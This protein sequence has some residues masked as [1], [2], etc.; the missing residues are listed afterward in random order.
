MGITFR[1]SGYRKRVNY[2]KRTVKQGEAMA[3]WDRYGTHYQIIGPR[4]V[5]LFSSTIEFLDNFIAKGNEYLYITH[6][7]GREEVIRGPTSMFCNPTF[8]RKIEVKEAIFLET[9]NDYI[10]VSRRSTSAT[11]QA[12]FASNVK[13]EVSLDAVSADGIRFDIIRGPMYFFPQVGDIVHS[14]D[15]SLIKQPFQVL[16][17][18]PKLFRFEPSTGES[19]GIKIHVWKQNTLSSSQNHSTTDSLPKPETLTVFPEIVYH[20]DDVNKFINFSDNFYGDLVAYIS[21]DIQE[22]ITSSNQNNNNINNESNDMKSKID[23]PN[24]TLK[25]EISYID[26]SVLFNIGNYQHLQRYCQKI[27]VVIESLRIASIDPDEHYKKQVNEKMKQLHEREKKFHEEEQRHKLADLELNAARERQNDLVEH[28]RKKLEA[29][30]E[31]ETKIREAR[32]Q[33]TLSF[34]DSLKQKGVDLNI[35]FQQV[36]IAIASRAAKEEKVRDHFA[37]V[38]RSILND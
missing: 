27:G 1:G 30:I 10:A 2:G 8:H 32:D 17:T 4:L 38:G 11:A 16:N 31:E 28:E 33:A 13:N 24:D 18:K 25:K 35:Y 21:R 29:K 15:W 6:V 23:E 3:V 36:G 37:D 19:K 12:F 22:L 26:Q 9:A 5:H 20:V 14:F 34:L 7:D